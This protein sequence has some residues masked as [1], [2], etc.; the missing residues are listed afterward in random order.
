MKTSPA[1]SDLLQQIAE[2]Q[3]MEPGKLCVTRTAATGPFYNLQCREKGKTRTRYVPREQVEQVR[4][5]TENYQQFQGLV[6]QYA[7]QVV[8]RTRAERLAGAK[9]KSPPQASSWR[10]TKK[11]SN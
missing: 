4:L 10:K 6:D 5:H 9:K 11:S 7:Q 8:E 1:P 3:R 2:I